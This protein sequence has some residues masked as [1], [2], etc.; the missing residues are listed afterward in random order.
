VVT[1]T[2]KKSRPHL[3]QRKERQIALR[4]EHILQ[5]AAS[6][7]ASRGFDGAQVGAIA[8]HAEVSLASVYALFPSKEQLFQAV[9]ETTAQ[10]MRD[11]VRARVEDVADPSERLLALIDSLFACFE[12]NGDLLRI[13]A[14]AT[15]GLPW[16]IRQSMGDSAQEIFS[17]F[18]NW[19]RDLVSDA[20][21]HGRFGDV[22]SE[23]LCLALI[24][25]VTTAAAAVAEETT[26]QS[27]AEIAAG[28]RSLFSRLLDGGADR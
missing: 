28:V 13:Y 4:R 17:E 10:S 23:A 27:L 15:H 22:S 2:T 9:I 18:T 7:F 6:E 19:V 24:G 20:L 3:L 5:A 25:S 26:S 11:A 14:R 12:A 16:R 1:K 21:R 8:S